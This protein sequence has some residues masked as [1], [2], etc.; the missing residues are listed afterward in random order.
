MFK[1]KVDH[2]RRSL[3]FEKNSFIFALHL[4]RPFKRCCVDRICNQRFAPQRRRCCKQGMVRFASERGC[5][6]MIQTAAREDANVRER[7]AALRFR[8]S[9]RKFAF[10]IAGLTK[11]AE[12]L[13]AV[14]VVD[15]RFD[16][17]VG[18]RFAIAI[19]NSPTQ[20][21]F[22]CARMMAPLER[23]VE[24]GTDRLTRRD[25]RHFKSP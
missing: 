18:D 22:A 10:G 7:R 12:A 6:V 23:F 24:E 4:N 25:I 11:Q 2:A 17:R 19:E 3:V 20:F 14:R 16:Q 9:K 13:N 5:E 8:Q 1:R 21:N 15:P